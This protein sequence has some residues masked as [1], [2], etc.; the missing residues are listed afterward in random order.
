[1]QI[2]DIFYIFS[3]G[4][5]TVKIMITRV[6]T[7]PFFVHAQDNE[8]NLYTYINRYNW[9]RNGKTYYILDENYDIIDP[10]CIYNYK[11]NTRIIQT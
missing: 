3:P 1:M 8:G 4:D 2:G 5:G 11:N 7:L 6:M 9:E 10:K